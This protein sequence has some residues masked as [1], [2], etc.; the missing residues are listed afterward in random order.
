MSG[1]ENRLTDL[2]RSSLGP[3]APEFRPLPGRHHH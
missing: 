2:A 3:F 1:E